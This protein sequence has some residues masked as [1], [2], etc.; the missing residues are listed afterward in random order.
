M[1]HEGVKRLNSILHHDLENDETAQP[2][3]SRGLEIS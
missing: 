2:I 3:D 1:F